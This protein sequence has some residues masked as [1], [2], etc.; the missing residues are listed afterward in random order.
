MQHLIEKVEEY[1]RQEELLSSGERVLLGVSGGAD[2]VALLL[3]L[4]EL[5]SPERLDLKLSVAHLDHGIRAEKA[6]ADAEFVCELAGKLALP[7]HQGSADVPALAKDHNISLEA[8][9][10]KARYE[11]F[12]RIAGQYHCSAV[13]LAHQADDQVETVLHRIIRGTGLTGVSGIQP[14]R[15]LSNQPSVRIVRPLLCCRRNEIE[16]FLRDK[17]T[18]WRLDHTNLQ[19][20]VTR[21]WI[22]NELL[23]QV[24]ER[25]NPRVDEALLRLADLAADASAFIEQHAKELLM[26]LARRF[27]SLICID[28]SALAEVHQALQGQIIRLSWTELGLG[29]RDMNLSLI[30]DILSRGWEHLDHGRPDRLALPDRGEAVYQFGKLML[31]NQDRPGVALEPVE[32][33]LGGRVSLELLGLIVGTQLLAKPVRLR[34][35]DPTLELIDGDCICGNLVIRSPGAAESFEPLAGTGCQ[36]IGQFLLSCKVPKLL[37]SLTPVLVDDRGIV[38][39]IG[40]RLADRVRLTDQTSRVVELSCRFSGR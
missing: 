27:D 12:I 28:L 6:R 5:A 19:S 30:K 3:V 18:S 35:E 8:A 39:V 16:Q 37:H 17:S 25:L 4:T 11:F 23:P 10:R 1:V 33:A 36:S 29:Q 15:L 31:V 26:K 7:F 13:G 24:R 20:D 34:H 14:Q 32:L 38:W 22:R 21:N 2:S 40:Y 9:G